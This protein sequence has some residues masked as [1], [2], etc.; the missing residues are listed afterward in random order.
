MRP[1]L[2]SFRR[3]P[4]AIR[5]RMALC[6]SGIEVDHREILL[7]DKPASMLAA[8]PKGT[9][10]VL[11][12]DDGIV[13]DESVEIMH[14]ALK[15]NDPDRWW[16]EE[17]ATEILALVNEN[18]FGFKTHLDHYKYWQ[19]FPEQSRTDYRE[20]GEGFLALLE[21]MLEQEEFILD[22]EMTF[23][24]MAIFPFI[25]QFA[26]VDKPWFDQTPYPHLHI[27]LES[28]LESSLFLRVM[29]KYP[30]WQEEST[31]LIA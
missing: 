2:Y 27:W 24:D 21:R 12:L 16:R 3:C 8:S 25:R 15:N 13:I 23:A 19:Q 28:L 10:P 5:A 6:Y 14:W 22:R 7:K 11:V 31:T 30:L 26:L 4:Y 20:A 9:V 1:I 17:S 18:D 29:E